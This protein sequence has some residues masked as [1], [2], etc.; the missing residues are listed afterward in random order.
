MY[1]K[2]YKTIVPHRDVCVLALVNMKAVGKCIECLV[3][4][5]ISKKRNAEAHD[6]MAAILVFQNNETAAMFVYKPILWEFNSFFH[7]DKFAGLLDT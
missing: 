3:L 4:V 1:T 2:M 7:S 5:A 6:V